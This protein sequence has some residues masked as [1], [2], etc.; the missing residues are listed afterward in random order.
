MY[1]LLIA[2]A[3]ITP[4]MS[5]IL[6]TRIC[7]MCTKRIASTARTKVCTLCKQICHALC[8]PGITKYDSCYLKVNNYDWYCVTCT[9]S[10]FPFNH[11]DDD[12]K[13]INILSEM[14]PT[15]FTVSIEELHE[16]S[17]IPFELNL[18]ECQPLYDTDPDLNYY[19]T[20]CNNAI[21]SEYYL[22]DSFNKFCERLSFDDNAFSLIH[23]NI[24]SIPKNMHE[25]ELY[26]ASLDINFTVLA[27]TET[28]F[29]DETCL[30]YNLDGYSIE[31][32][33]R[34]YRKGGGVALY[35]RDSLM[36]K[37]RHDLDIYDDVMESKFVEIQKGSIGATRDAIV[38]VIYR[39]PNTDVSLFNAR[40]HT[41]LSKIK[42]ENKICYL[43]GDYNINLLSTETHLSTSEF[44]ETMFSHMFIPLVNRP[45]RVKERSA[46]IIDNI[47]VNYYG[48]NSC[49]SGILYTDISDHFPVFC[50]DKAHKAEQKLESQYKRIY[51]HKNQRDFKAALSH[52]TWDDVLSCFD[53]QAAYSSFFH[54][55]H[56][57]YNKCFPLKEV[58][59]NYYNRK[60]WLSDHLKY[61]I[62]RKNELYAK[63]KHSGAYYLETYY[64]EYKRILQ[65]SLRQA[66]KDYYEKIF[67]ENKSNLVKSWKII[68]NVINKKSTT[69]R[70]CK[71][72]INNKEIDD[73]S[74][75][76]DKFNDFYVNLG[77]TLAKKLPTSTI[78][79]ISY[80]KNGINKTI[81]LRPVNEHEVLK[82][83]KNMKKSS[84]GWDELSP[85]IV[86]MTYS[87]FI[88]PLTHICNVSLMNGVFPDELKVAKV[89]PIYKGG[90]SVYLVNY[91]PVSVLPIFSKIFEKLMYDRVLEFINE[92]NI[93][94]KLQ[95]GFRKD[96]STSIALMILVDK[97]SKAMHEG[98]YVLGVFIDFSKAF[99]TVNHDILLRK[100]YAYGIR[101]VALDWF[102]SY[103]SNRYQY[104][105]YFDTESSKQKISCGVPQGSI[106]GPLLFLLYINDIAYVSD[107]L[108]L[109]LFADDTNAFVSGKNVNELINLMNVELAKLNDWLY[110]NKL[111]LNVA[112]THYLIFRSCRNHK[113][114]FDEELVINGEIV[115]QDHKTKFLGVILDEFLSW[116]AHISYIKNKIAKGIGVICKVRRLLNNQTLLTL[117]YCFV[118]P[119]FNYA[120]EVWGEARECYLGP[121][122][123]LQKRVVRIITGSSRLEHT[124]PLFKELKLLQLKQVHVYKV[125][126]I[127]FRVWHYKTPHVFSSLFIRNEEFHS[128]NTRQ[129]L[130]FHVPIARTDYM[131]RAISSKG[132]R[133]WNSVC[134]HETIDCSYVSFKQSLKKRLL[135]TEN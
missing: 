62:Q 113:P 9:S 111:S 108:Y 41:L 72:I 34:A 59:M 53:P 91:R 28:W 125:G 6:D 27:F 100:L 51:S 124:A 60:P 48:Q 29:K 82:I 130:Q 65:K 110:A 55:L 80:I 103:L 70:P 26:L 109:I 117:Y 129:Y 98:E 73:K 12:Y 10:M 50:I 20:I 13:F 17:F 86:K 61:C 96:H 14:W 45:T 69:N 74:V 32:S 101:G 42:L 115:K 126:L 92:N 21:N 131:K 58:K 97:I 8:V 79:P 33:H 112:K 35:L 77:P 93:L 122:F 68:K 36:Y 114:L 67:A 18:D 49:F 19:T 75:I 71:F 105:R 11:Y 38:G 90:E 81:F 22:E 99:D 25:F 84:S 5:Q 134:C 116:D 54:D 133:I 78:D 128:Y 52:A 47:F 64:T 30:L 88:G 119:Y 31:S 2:D 4:D 39:P 57:K 1:Y 16:K 76:A 24:R 106:L 87:Y 107:I 123:R 95:F 3:L 63:I 120:L 118:Y 15:T 56:E 46:T 23:L 37:L 83:L 121:L 89:I 102:A 7:F 94:H 66:E 40:I 43:L 104:V 132:V 127:M 85:H 135:Q 44:V